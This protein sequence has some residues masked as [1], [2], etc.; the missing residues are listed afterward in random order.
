MHF[1]APN[2]GDLVIQNISFKNIFIFLMLFIMPAYSM[3]SGA[4]SRSSL[5]SHNIRK[6][7]M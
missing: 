2:G 1:I 5:K 7:I 3:V 6:M 4:L